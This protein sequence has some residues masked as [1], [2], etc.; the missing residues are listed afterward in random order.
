VFEEQL[1]MFLGQNTINTINEGI[2]FDKVADVKDLGTA[3]EKTFNKPYEYGEVFA[4]TPERALEAFKPLP[5]RQSQAPRPSDKAMN[6]VNQAK[7]QPAPTATPMNEYD[8]ELARRGFY[9]D[10]NGQWVKGK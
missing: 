9:K 7:G 3:F 10:A 1:G 6:R 2:V 8:K 5:Q 4:S